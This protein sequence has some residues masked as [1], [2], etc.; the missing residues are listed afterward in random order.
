MEKMA[1]RAMNAP[2]RM[3]R[4]NML[5]GL[6]CAFRTPICSALA[7]ISAGISASN[8]NSLLTAIKGAPYLADILP[9]QATGRQ[10]QTSRG[11]AQDVIGGRWRRGNKIGGQACHLG[12]PPPAGETTAN[13]PG[14][15]EDDPGVRG[16]LIL[17]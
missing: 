10:W 16:L 7:A 15:P 2:A 14:E 3:A 1:P 9:G 17:F 11:R 12:S 5:T 8:C 4:T 6:R 13:P